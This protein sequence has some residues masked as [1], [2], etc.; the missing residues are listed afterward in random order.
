MLYI[1]RHYFKNN[2]AEA[3]SAV[4][5]NHLAHLKSKGAAL[6]IAGPITDNSG[7]AVGGMS[8]IEF[9]S[10][11]EA[12]SF[13]AADPYTSANIVARTEISAFTGAIGKWLG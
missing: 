11:N 6:K 8:I 3:R 12:S 13:T 2:V 4:R 7:E 10:A 5:A 9:N 1:I